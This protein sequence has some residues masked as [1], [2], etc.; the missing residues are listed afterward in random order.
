M[1]KADTDQRKVKF[2]KHL[3]CFLSKKTETGPGS[4]RHLLIMLRFAGGIWQQEDTSQTCITQM[5]KALQRVVIE[6]VY[7]IASWTEAG[8]LNE[9][10]RRGEKRPSITLSPN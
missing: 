9:L 5:Y 1:N 10:S 7:L 8:F 6:A 2:Q 4:V 3:S